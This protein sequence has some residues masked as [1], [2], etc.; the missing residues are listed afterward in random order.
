MWVYS[1]DT[2]EGRGSEMAMTAR[3]IPGIS[4][5]ARIEA[6]RRMVGRKAPAAKPAEGEAKAGA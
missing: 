3:R 2:C 4:D 6:E 1:N 5:A